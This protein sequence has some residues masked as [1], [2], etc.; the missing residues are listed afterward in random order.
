MLLFELAEIIGEK[1]RTK[2]YVDLAAT[3]IRNQNEQLWNEELD[4]TMPGP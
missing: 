4:N 3:A 2:G 1:E